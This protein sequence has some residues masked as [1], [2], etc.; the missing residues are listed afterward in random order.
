MHDRME[1]GTFALGALITGGEVTMDG[2]VEHWLGA[3]TN[4]MR[5]VGAE[6][7][8]GKDVYRVQAPEEILP[9]DIQTYPYPGFPTDLQAPFATMLTQ[10]EGRSSVYETMYDGRLRYVSDLRRMGARIDVSGSGRNAMVHG[11]TPLHGAKVRALDIRSGAAM[12]LAGLAAEGSTQISDVVYVDRGYQDITQKL[13][14]LGAVVSRIQES[15]HQCPVQDRQEPIEWG[16][17]PSNSA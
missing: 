8:T 3:L 5:A 17:M 12:I 15:D 4:K 7:T 13:C 16:V 10:A 9:T 1:A 14:S 6:V 2:A 11:P